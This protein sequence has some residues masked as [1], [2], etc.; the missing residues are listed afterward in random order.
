MRRNRKTKIIS[1]LILWSLLPPVP[2]QAGT[3]KKIPMQKAPKDKGREPDQILI[4]FKT[5]VGEQGRRAMMA[6]HQLTLGRGTDPA[7]RASLLASLARG[8]RRFDVVIGLVTSADGDRFLAR[9]FYNDYL[10]RAPD[11]EG[12]P[13]WWITLN[14]GVSDQ[15]VTSQFLSSPEYVQ[16]AN[17]S[18]VRDII[19][20]IW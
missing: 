8:A 17:S 3:Y 5:D 12:F 13:G 18:R 2:L 9:H 6:A 14:S 1:A 19:A 7:G 16:N 4:K 20:L 11:P 15:R 10:R